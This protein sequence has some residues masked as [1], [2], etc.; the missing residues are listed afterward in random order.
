MGL[1]ETEFKRLNKKKKLKI[2]TKES[3]TDRTEQNNSR[4]LKFTQEIIESKGAAFL[5][6]KRLPCS[7]SHAEAYTEQMDEV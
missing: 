1:T 5:I 7:Q 4:M 3:K 2:V 6:P